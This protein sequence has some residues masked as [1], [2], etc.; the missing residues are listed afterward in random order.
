M[1]EWGKLTA[2][3]TPAL[4]PFGGTLGGPGSTKAEQKIREKDVLFHTCLSPQFLLSWRQREHEESFDPEP[5][6]EQHPSNPQTPF[7]S[8]ISV[9]YVKTAQPGRQ[10]P[11]SLKCSLKSLRKCRGRVSDT[12][13]Q[14]CSG[15]R[16]TGREGTS[17]QRG[18]GAVTQQPLTLLR[19]LPDV[20][21]HWQEQ[22]CDAKH[23]GWGFFSP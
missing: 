21:Q 1:G 10:L 22:E 2:R 18:P 11:Y 4:S 17:R 20:W 9:G 6:M 16:W 23:K 14:R 3:Q 7:Y 12:G 5:T 15:S 19:C 8:S 13:Q